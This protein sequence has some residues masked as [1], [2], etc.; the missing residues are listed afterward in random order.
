MTQGTR[1]MWGLCVRITVRQFT[2]PDKPKCKFLWLPCEPENLTNPYCSQ[3][4]L[5]MYWT[6]VY[7]TFAALVTASTQLWHPKLD[8]SRRQYSFGPYLD[9]LQKTTFRKLYG[10]H[11]DLVHKFDTSVSHTLNGLFTN[12]DTWLVSNCFGNRD[13]SNMWG[14]KCS[15]F[16]ECLISLRLGSS[17]FHSFIIYITEFVS[18]R[19]MFTD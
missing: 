3:T 1:Y 14:R 13:G 18:F 8:Q 12:C 10:R 5:K 15:L 11:T 2:H 7:W 9:P 4:D 6:I 19:N 17:W 16:P